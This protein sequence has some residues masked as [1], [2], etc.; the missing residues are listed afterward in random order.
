MIFPRN[1]VRRSTLRVGVAPRCHF[2]M[3]FGRIPRGGGRVWYGRGAVS[4]GC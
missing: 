4:A 1:R 3:F 2:S